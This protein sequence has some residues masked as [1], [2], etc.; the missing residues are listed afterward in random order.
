VA[1]QWFPAVSST[2]KADRNNIAE[3]LL[4]LALST[5]IQG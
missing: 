2:K 4:K 1:D 5:I 3:I